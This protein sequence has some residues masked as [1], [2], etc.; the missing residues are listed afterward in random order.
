MNMRKR[1]LAIM[2]AMYYIAANAMW[3]RWINSVLKPSPEEVAKHKA[4]HEKFWVEIK[5]KLHHVNF[6][7]ADTVWKVARVKDNVVVAECLTMRDAQEMIE[8]A[9]RQK[10]AK[11]YLLSDEPYQYPPSDSEEPLVEYDPKNFVHMV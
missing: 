9:A 4:E 7:K 3:D 1:K 6:P 5:E 8:R 11:L 2:T 10:K